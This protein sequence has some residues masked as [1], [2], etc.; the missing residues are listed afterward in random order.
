M[1]SESVLAVRNTV[2]SPRLPDKRE[3]GIA[4]VPESSMKVNSV[5]LN[6]RI[7]ISEK[8]QNF[9]QGN[10]HHALLRPPPKNGHKTLTSRDLQCPL[11]NYHAPL[12]HVMH[13]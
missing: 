2:K 9:C 5:E 6:P 8:V 11:V 3:T 10:Q 1:V 4:F 7:I 13:H 12:T